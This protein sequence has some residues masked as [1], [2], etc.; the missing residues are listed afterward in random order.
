LTYDTDYS[1]H[2]SIV[3]GDPL[4][5]F[6]RC[7]RTI[8]ISRGDWRTRVE[9]TS[10]LSSTATTFTITNV[11]DAYEGEARIHSTTRALTLPRDHV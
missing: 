3:E 7:D 5:A 8:R 10:T 4:S 9:T 2:F 6:I 1:D 11:L